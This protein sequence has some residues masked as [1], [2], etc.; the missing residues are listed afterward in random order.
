MSRDSSTKTRVQHTGVEPVGVDAMRTL[1]LVVAAQ[2]VDAAGPAMSRIAA[3][4]R[5]D[6]RGIAVDG[7]HRVRMLDEGDAEVRHRDVLWTREL[8]ACATRS[9]QRR[10]EFIR[11][12]AFQRHD[13]GCRCEALDE[14]RNGRPDDRAADDRDVVSCASHATRWSASVHGAPNVV[15]MRVDS[16]MAKLIGRVRRSPFTCTLANASRVAYHMAMARDAEWNADGYAR[17]SGLQEAMAHEALALLSLQ[18]TEQVLDVGCG[19]GKITA[20]IAARVPRGAV[21][22]VDPSHDMIAFATSHFTRADGSN[23]RF[24]VADARALPFGAEFDLVVSFNALHW[25]P[26]QDAA[27]QSIRRAVKPGGRVLLRLVP[28]GERVSL[29]TV[30]EE[31]RTSARWRD[32]FSAFW[33]RICGSRRNSTAPSPSEMVFACCISIACRRP[34]TSARAKLFAFCAVGL[35]AWTSRL[36][37]SERAAFIDDVLDRYAALASEDPAARTTFRFYQMDVQLAP[38]TDAFTRPT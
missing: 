15:R 28:M 9:A 12:V 30:V 36:A 18:G 29:E 4:A 2:R 26:D 11:A 23:L 5:F 38:S 3:L 7:E 34:G 20:Q 37:Q 16:N 8:A 14:V 24:Q 13:A 31:T 10:G 25:I 35:V 19:Q 21:V 1:D 6:V 27:L 17:I 33:I 32:R 22:G